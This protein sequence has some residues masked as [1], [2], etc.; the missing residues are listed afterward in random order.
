MKNLLPL[1][2][3]FLALPTLAQFE[4]K[5]GDRVTLLGG[6]F[7]EREGEYG[8]IETA[9]TRLWPDRAITFRN[10]GWSG[11]TV[12]G[13]S[14]GYNVLAD[15]Y[16]NLLKEVRK[17]EPTVLFLA[18]GATEAWAG[19][20]G[21]A[22]FQE[23]YEKLL[24]DLADLKARIVLCTP[25]F[26]EHHPAPLPDPA[27]QNEN[28][29]RYSQA[30]KALAETHKHTFCDLRSV[31]SAETRYTNNSLHLTESGY[32]HAAN[33]FLKALGHEPP[34]G[35]APQLRQA[36]VAKNRLHF[37][38]WRPQN[39]T[40]I[41]AFRKHE[42]GR[43]AKDIPAFY[44]LIEAAEAS[45]RNL[46][47]PEQNPPPALAPKPPPSVSSAPVGVWQELPAP[48]EDAL[49]DLQGFSLP[50]D[51]Q[52]N[53]FASEPA[54]ANPIQS[55]WDAE[56]RLWV[57]TAES[58]PHINPEHLNNDKI[59]VF[60]DS[61]RDGRADRYKIFADSLLMPT[62]I[63]PGDGGVYVGASTQFMHLKDSDGDG[64]ADSKNILI[65]GFG[66]EDTHH[67][68]H[69]LR[70]DRDGHITI[71]QSIYINSHFETPFGPRRHMKSCVWRYNRG[72]HRLEVINAGLVNPW[73]YV[74]DRY[75]QPFMTDG[76]GGHGINYAFPGA[77]FATAWN[78]DRKDILSGL[79]PG[80]PKMCGIE[81]ISGRHFPE[82]YQGLLIANDF[83]G[84]RTCAFRLTDDKSGF[85][86]TQEA[87]WVKSGSG[88]LDRL[89]TG[90]GYRPV[91]LD[92][93]PDGAL[94]IT[95]W[96]NIIIQHGE[97]D[98]LDPRRDRTHGR[99]WR[100]TAKDRPALPYPD[101]KAA[102]ALHA[103]ED[104]T[105]T[106][107]QVHASGS[108]GGPPAP[109]ESDLQALD[110]LHLHQSK[111]QPNPDLLKRLLK[112][113]DFRIRAAAVR[114]LSDW[115]TDTSLYPVLIADAHPRVRLETICALR[116]WPSHEA[117]ALAL[118]ARQMP[119]D[120]N[121]DFALRQTMRE[122]RPHWEGNAAFKPSLDD[123]AYLVR[124]TGSTAP[125][126]S[127][128]AALA[129]LPAAQRPT[130][131]G[132]IAELGSDEQRSKLI[133]DASLPVAERRLVLDKAAA[134][135]PLK[136]KLASLFDHPE[137]GG[138]AL[139][140][141]AK[142]KSPGLAAELEKRL[143][144]GPS[145]AK[146]RE[147]ANNL[148]TIG[149]RDVLGKAINTHPHPDQ[150]I[151]PLATL[152]PGQAAGE[153]IKRTPA[154][155]AHTPLFQAILA[156]KQGAPNLVKALQGKTIP[157]DFAKA[158][159]DAANRSGRKM[160]QVVD[161]LTKAGGLAALP[162]QLSPEQM[163]ALIADIASG[164]PT[165]GEH[166]YRR[167]GLACVTCHAI[168]GAGGSIGPDLVSVGASAPVDY[169]IDS[170]L[171]P[172]KKIKEGYATTLV[173]TKGG[174]VHAGVEV[175]ADAKIVRLRMPDDSEK[176]VAV[177]DIAKKEIVPTSLMPPG[178]TAAL[179]RA[180]FIDLV[181]F[182]AKLG[183][184]GYLPPQRVIR[185]V[186]TGGRP[187]TA[188]LNGDFLV[189]E[190]ADRQISFPLASDQ[191][192]RT[193]PG[194]TMTQNA[195]VITLTVG[196]DYLGKTVRLELE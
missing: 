40:Y 54:F 106:W 21:I 167:A 60:E 31:T 13:D 72:S 166:I 18:Y 85:K 57:A 66:T 20:D 169:I 27:A 69:G 36:I 157:A 81:V 84:H 129:D 91:D 171:E 146:T 191:K 178:L 5:D 77:T 16:R 49:K 29:E 103:P 179:P 181:A 92:M 118:K 61:D 132:L 127:L 147:L 1:L 8:H 63:L 153:A 177:A 189:A 75:N 87:D 86:S 141:A 46:L 143:H 96:S 195:G 161:A 89:G 159:I 130:V 160:P 78:V 42:Q 41:Y 102:D 133:T 162:P 47:T 65:S 83:R 79:N 71:L 138:R 105:R 112:S 156:H 48:S 113:E 116:N 126:A 193:P 6:T 74:V 176:A 184:E 175:S 50:D 148:A 155:W 68:I 174:Q 163:R 190:F 62:A 45:I 55:A 182:L 145:P 23:G 37:H 11:D 64:A 165:G 149:A 137:L 32:A 51:L 135:K 82:H 2:L 33:E 172:A 111:F 104:F 43:H 39:Q 26:Q 38:A 17:T 7:I 170:L 95:D 151:I 94:Y 10:L 168:G 152:A 3:L 188:L 123:S 101:V 99:I 56:G 131:L 120:V 142:W 58:Y 144:A 25:L 122:L 194:T 76:A 24:A 59:L 150:I 90:G 183:T 30:I 187:L 124:S 158:G 28:L 128:Y 67:V 100:I 115:Q 110:I 140:L 70:Y 121:I 186:N 34:I 173:T 154:Q 80:Q 44:P 19:A 52:I 53:L 125:I 139:R 97:I 180:E 109:P 15:G 117:A 22:K 107:A 14:R 9:L 4:L 73:G 12:W 88:G 134:G 98:F 114:V 196:K 192:L 164:D 119:T 108:G 136:T 93:G 35:D 185:Q